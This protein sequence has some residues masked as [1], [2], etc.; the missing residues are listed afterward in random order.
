[1]V[2]LSFKD[3]LSQEEINRV[4]ESVVALK[5]EIPEIKQVTKGVCANHPTEQELARGLTHSFIMQFESE[6]ERDTYLLHPVHVKVAQE[7]VI[8][9]LREGGIIVFDMK[10]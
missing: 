9:A 1:M 4:I 5:E 7:I 10:V 3:G 8:P 2:M 6:A